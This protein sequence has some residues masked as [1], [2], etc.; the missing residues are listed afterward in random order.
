MLSVLDCKFINGR[1]MLIYFVNHCQ[2][3]LKSLENG[4]VNNEG[5]TSVINILIW[6]D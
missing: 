2:E 1:G 6:K 4:F 5:K 3:Q